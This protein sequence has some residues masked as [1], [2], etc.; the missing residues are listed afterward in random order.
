MVAPGIDA[1]ARQASALREAGRV[2]EAI[3]A[4]ELLLAQAPELPNSWYNLALLRR[5][6]RRPDGALVA[7]ERALALGIE[8]PEEVH[9]NRGVIYSDDLR[10]PDAA[11][12]ELKRALQLNPRYA[13]A[14]LNLGN[15]HEDAGRRD[16]ARAAYA[17]LLEIDP[18]HAE[19][20]ARLAG[21]SNVASPD[22]ALVGRLRERIAQ[23]PMRADETA[24]L[25]FALGRLLDGCGAYDA[26]FTAYAEANRASR[27][28]AGAGYDRAR[29]SAFV[30][31]LIEASPVPVDPAAAPETA[32]P[33]PLFICGMFRSGSTL[34]EQVLAGHAEITP[35]GELD[36][37][38]A[39]ARALAPFPRGLA[40]A[41]RTRLAQL[42]DGYRSELARLFPGARTVT[43]KRP[44][45]YLS[46]G[47][48]KALFP[49]AKIVHTRRDALDN[50]LSIYFLHLAHSQPYATDLADIGHHYQEY[51]RLMAHWRALYPDD[52]FDFDYDRFVHD[53]R[54]E[55]ERLL[56]FC[57]LPWDERCLDFH[58]RPNAVKTASVWQVRQPLYT[59][60]SG[61]WRRYA[62]H[63]APLAEALGDTRGADQTS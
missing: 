33:R 42:A 49:A 11:L 54:P 10:R 60:S 16:E 26:A 45:N 23:R 31:A 27:H 44:D 52:I 14:W 32:A 39:L 19:A 38:P 6:A 5:K 1:L 51:R 30:D 12:A 4:Y 18:R 36:L 37:L 58:Q 50:G 53:P 7:Y 25:G 57:G 9:L 59:A 15:L 61:R 46:I 55:L 17:R 21:V 43:D 20:L 22:D 41:D 56:A 40:T 3:D 35:G 48:V 24:T 62:A 47:L 28:G 2:G 34:V 8:Q 29:H 13:P 63:L